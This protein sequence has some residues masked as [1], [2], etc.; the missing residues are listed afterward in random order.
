MPSVIAHIQ[1]RDYGRIAVA[2]ARYTYFGR[3]IMRT[4]T[5]TGTDT[6]VNAEPQVD[7]T[8][9][10]GHKIILRHIRH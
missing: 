6:T 1:G 5:I 2:L 9:V 3:S 7:E 8:T 10:A 4:S